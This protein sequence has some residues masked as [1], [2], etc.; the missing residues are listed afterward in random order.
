MRH[1]KGLYLICTVEMWERFSYYGMRALLV[2]FLTAQLISGGLGFDDSS[3]SLIYGIFTGLIYFTPLI[4]GWLSDRYLG[5]RKAISLG[6]WF[7]IAGQL[8][9][10][11]STTAPI[12]YVSLLLQIFGNGLFKPSS[13]V[14]VGSLY[15]EGDSRIDSAYTIFYMGINL[16]SFFSPILT[17]WLAVNYGFKY[18]FLASAT[19]LILGYLNYTILSNRYLGEICKKPVRKESNSNGTPSEPLTKE[20]KHR[21]WV[22]TIL[23]LFAI[24]FFAGFEQAGCSMTI[25]SEKYVDRSV[26]DFNV[27]TA[28]LQ[29][30][31]P[32]FIL[33]LAPLFSFM[34]TK[35]GDNGRNPSI[36]TKMGLGLIMLGIGFIFMIGAIYDIGGDVNT[37]NDNSG[38]ASVWFIFFAYMFHTIGEL[39]LSPIGLSMVSRLAPIKLASMLM[40]VWMAS[41][42]VA[43]FLAGYLAS[44]TP[45]YGYF[46]LYAGL[47]LSSIVL[48]I[49]LIFI[50][51]P[52]L[53]MSYG[54]I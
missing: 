53:K 37:F 27:P 48:G 31:N 36:P 11:F 33:L 46:E 26:L 3:A 44:Y 52:L 35:L 49:I 2:L 32:L 6:L 12:L 40:G 54:R 20:E 25:F 47:T 45:K 43:N 7:L 14:I 38:K 5:Q 51:K 13:T 42:A 17:G 22:I 4:G 15:P 39:C 16:G 9:M 41:S 10:A 28:W 8:T 19:G 50:R 24:A 1:P 29:S 21:I 30:I 18:G 23:T 34:W